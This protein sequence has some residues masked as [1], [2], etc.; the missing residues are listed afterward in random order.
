[1]APERTLYSGN[2]VKGVYVGNRDLFMKKFYDP[3]RMMEIGTTFVRDDG[4]VFVVLN[5]NIVKLTNGFQ[6]I[7]RELL[8]EQKP[9]PK[10]PEKTGD[11]KRLEE[12]CNNE[13]EAIRKLNQNH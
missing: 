10:E 4:A 13:I 8:I 5:D 2:R 12:I 1:M 7:S 9:L 3:Q 11:R 6:E